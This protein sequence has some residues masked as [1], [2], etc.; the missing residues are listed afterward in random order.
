[1]YSVGKDST[2]LFVVQPT[3]RL[4]VFTLPLGEKDLRANV[5]SFRNLI[6]RR[7][8]SGPALV[9]QGKRLYDTLVKPAETL[10]EESQRVV[11]LPDGPLHI[12]PFAALVRDERKG[13][14]SYFVE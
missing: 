8:G 1:S 11:I 3:P 14:P 4:S 2:Q 12:L 7:T 13:H 6:D 5:E 10:I 9:S